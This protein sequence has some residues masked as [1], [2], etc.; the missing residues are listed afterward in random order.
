MISAALC[1]FICAL[2]TCIC[3]HVC[4][5]RVQYNH[6]IAIPIGVEKNRTYNTEFYVADAMMPF[7]RTKKNVN[8]IY[9][10]GINIVYINSKVLWHCHKIYLFKIPFWIIQFYPYKNAKNRY[11][12]MYIWNVN[13]LFWVLRTITVEFLIPSLIFSWLVP[14]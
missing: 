4:I 10:H 6:A 14:W 5:P 13:I 1:T 2:H 8:E 11:L 3:P 9:V 7:Y 12:F